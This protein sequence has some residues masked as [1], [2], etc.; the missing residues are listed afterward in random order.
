MALVQDAVSDGATA[1][2]RPEAGRSRAGQENVG[3]ILDAALSVF[4]TF[5]YRGSRIE[6][7]A[8]AAGLSK[9]NL[10]YYFRTKED[11]YLAVLQRTLDMWLEPLRT[12]DPARDPADAFGD[13]IARKLAASRD[14]PAASRLFAL[15]VIQGAPILGPVLEK[16]LKAIVEDSAGT[17]ARWIEQGKLRPVLPRHLIY[18]VW[19]TTQH[20]ADFAA[21]VRAIEGRDLSDPGFFAEACEHV[22]ATILQGVL[23]R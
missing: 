20:Y 23:P 1:A 21:Q 4:A 15:E 18:S 3:R 5:G 12:L 17:I 7:I 14:D 13:Y 2:G 8:A 10:L 11:L 19:A 9:T 6:Q 22:T 16:E